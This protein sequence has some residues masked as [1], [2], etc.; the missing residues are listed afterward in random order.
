[1]WKPVAYYFADN[2]QHYR[3]YSL[4][5]D[6]SESLVGAVG[7]CVVGEVERPDQITE[8]R[9]VPRVNLVTYLC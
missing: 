6:S 7:R 4:P 3:C 1:V 2:Q 9:R 5:G 8:L